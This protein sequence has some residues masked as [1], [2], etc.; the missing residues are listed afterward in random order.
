MT[1]AA[2][3]AQPAA[4][5]PERP[6]KP[7]PIRKAIKKRSKP[8]ERE[9]D[10]TPALPPGPL[11]IIVSIDK[12]RVTLFAGGVPVAHSPISSGTVGHP[13][14]LGVFSVLQKRRHHVSNLYDAKMPYMQRLTWSG[15]AMHQ[16]PLPG[17]PASHG[18]IRLPDEF[19]QLLWKATKIGARVII[20]RDE[21]APVA[22]QHANLFTPRPQDPAP[23]LV[24]P[25]PKPRAAILVKT[26]D[27][28]NSVPVAVLADA[29]K[30][31][32]DKPMIGDASIGEPL[33]ATPVATKPAANSYAAEQPTKMTVDFE[34]G[35]V[36]VPLPKQMIADGIRPAAPRVLDPVVARITPSVAAPVT[37]PI[38]V[39]ILAEVTSSVT[40][41]IP[42]ADGGPAGSQPALGV[43]AK[44]RTGPVSVF[45]SRRERK[46]YVRQGMEP[47]FD[48]AV[49]IER[50]DQTIGTHVFTA[51]GFNADRSDMR[52][53]V[54]SIP[55]AYKQPVETTKSGDSKKPRNSRAIKAAEQDAGPPPSPRAALDRIV[56]PPDTVQRIAELVTPGSSLIVSDNKLSDE[57]GA[58]TD[59]IVETR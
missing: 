28:T 22:I 1:A 48:A 36:T 26:A 51:M 8:A 4:A 31:A 33:I 44:R 57:T 32:V 42:A 54:V 21:V 12:Q 23:P 10:T 40:V 3:P 43:E 56:M 52:W 11:H 18:C 38:T 59:F 47:L 39:P 50:P 13:T 35:A 30:P 45:V 17:R 24:G 2:S 53:T 46:L 25:P 20:T 19:A 37:V 27:A 16:G 7:S 34:T 55:S 9:A 15:T 14:P 49:A 5:E 6:A 29:V 41:P 58:T